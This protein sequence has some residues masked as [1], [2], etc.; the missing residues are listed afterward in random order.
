M[1]PRSLIVKLPLPSS[2]GAPS[3]A[4]PAADPRT[5]DSAAEAAL[6]PAVPEGEDDGEMAEPAGSE[7]PPS[8]TSR[9]RTL[10]EPNP[11]NSTFTETTKTPANSLDNKAV[12]HSTHP[13]EPQNNFRPSLA[14]RE[15]STR[16]E[17]AT[18]TPNTL[19]SDLATSS[20]RSRVTTTLI[21]V[22]DQG[23]GEMSV[24]KSKDSPTSLPP[25][26]QDIGSSLQAAE[27]GKIRGPG[28]KFMPKSKENLS[29]LAEAPGATDARP[30]RTRTH[31][32]TYNEPILSG[33]AVHTPTKYREQHHKNVVRGGM[34]APMGGSYIPSNLSASHSPCVGVSEK[35]K[36][37]TDTMAIEK[38][39]KKSKARSNKEEIQAMVPHLTATFLNYLCNYGQADFAE[40]TSLNTLE[41]ELLRNAAALPG[42]LKHHAYAKTFPRVIA[43]WITFR[44]VIFDVQGEAHNTEELTVMELKIKNSR[45]R[46]ELR[47][48]R[49]AFVAL[50]DEESSA[51]EILCWG[52]GVLQS[53][54]NTAGEGEKVED[55]CIE[56]VRRLDERLRELGGRL[57]DGDG[58]WI[59]M[60]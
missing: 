31:V 24:P 42:L 19:P 25:P 4:S 34:G 6:L 44:I 35:E 47:K 11:T 32:P 2:L 21:Q 27:R 30:M 51:A 10:I 40:E 33:F 14:T 50:G 26:S 16:T 3:S 48:A 15:P 23:S 28:G 1:P 60:G 49:D 53:L 17:P 29:A 39:A 20:S 37:Q 7:A 56:G 54:Q 22:G 52:F 5:Y 45:L 9:E 12:Q 58:E 8:P 46:T 18:V 38:A 59:M 41:E 55:E 57:G 13:K 36:Q 43:A